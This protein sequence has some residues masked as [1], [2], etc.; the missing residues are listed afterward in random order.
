MTAMVNRQPSLPANVE[1]YIRINTF[2]GGST[3]VMLETLGPPTGTLQPN[4]ELVAKY[5]G[6][7]VLPPEL[8]EMAREISAAVRQYRETNVI[9]HIDEQVQRLGKVLD[10]IDSLVGDPQLREDVR[11]AIANLRQT[12]EQAQRIAGDVE[13]FSGNLESLRSD[14]AETL[15]SARKT[16][17][18][19]DEE[20]RK[21]SRE[22]TDRLGQ[23]TQL[24]KQVSSTL[25]KIERGD[26]TAGA[27]LTDRRLYEGLVD[28]TR[29]LQIAIRDLQR[30]I[31]QW[32]QEGVPMRLR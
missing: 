12:S 24:M 14:A 32:E 21:L 22:F 29:E 15:G 26:G 20:I 6:L 28:T 10:S 19:A 23:A 13:K 11:Q 8:A 17:T 2:I 16:F 25:E 27:L 18:T 3:S 1:G 9:V 7:A 4:A 30:L 5:V 31:R